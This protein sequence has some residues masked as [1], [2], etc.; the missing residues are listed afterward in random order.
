MKRKLRFIFIHFIIYVLFPILFGQI[1]HT[2]VIPYTPPPKCFELDNQ[3][4]CLNAEQISMGAE[5]AIK[6]TF[7]SQLLSKNEVRQLALEYGLTAET[8]I[9]PHLKFLGGD[10]SFW[11]EQEISEHRLRLEF[12]ARKAILDAA[13]KTEVIIR[14]QGMLAWA[15]QNIMADM[16]KMIKKIKKERSEAKSPSKRPVDKSEKLKTSPSKVLFTFENGIEQ[17]QG[18]E[19]PVSRVEKPAAD[20]NGSLR[21]QVKLSGQG[22]SDNTIESPEINADFSQQDEIKLQILISKDAPYGL[23]CQVFTKSGENWKWNDNG[24]PPLKRGE[25]TTL[26]MLTSMI[27]NKNHVRSL[28]VKIGGNEKYEG[29]V[30]ID[31]V[32]IIAHQSKKQPAKKQSSK[33]QPIIEIL[34]IEP[35]QYITGKVEGLD[36]EQ[37]SQFKILVYVKTDK[38]YIHPYDRGGEGMTYASINSD[39][40]WKIKTVKRTFEADFVV[41]AL[42]RNDYHSPPTVHYLEDIESIAFCKEK[43]K[44]RL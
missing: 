32:E 1:G 24:W 33:K 29:Y 31:N 26:S 44:G 5:K 13:D 21:C 39:G 20:D 36:Q 19:G 15:A 37:Y 17:W 42:V 4:L 30:Y 3:S 40:F 14:D 22:W 43:G 28:G 38:W 8:A 16:L 10:I 6:D 18:Y 34:D 2:D 11:F 12:A 41:A 25:W 7:K 23:K 35:N 9:N 27:N